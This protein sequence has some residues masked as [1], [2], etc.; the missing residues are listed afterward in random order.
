MSHVTYDHVQ[1]RLIF[2]YHVF[3]CFRWTAVH[4]GMILTIC[5][6]QGKFKVSQVAYFDT[7]LPMSEEC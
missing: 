5:M 1:R 6:N 4:P 3:F 2:M 7:G